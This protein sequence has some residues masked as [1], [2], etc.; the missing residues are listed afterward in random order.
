MLMMMALTYLHPEP[1]QLPLL[2]KYKHILQGKKLVLNLNAWNQHQLWQTVKSVST[3][4][5]EEGLVRIKGF[6]VTIKDAAF[7]LIKVQ[8]PD[9][10]GNC[11]P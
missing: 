3:F 4:H 10:E 6:T 9:W 5:H 11:F 7:P 2:L 1:V 8:F